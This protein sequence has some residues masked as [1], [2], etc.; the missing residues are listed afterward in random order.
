[1]ALRLLVVAVHDVVAAD[2]D[3][4]DGLHV[5]RHVVHLQVDD[6]DLAARQRPAGHGLAAEA[7]VVVG[8]RDGALVAGAGGN[9]AALGEAVA[10]HDAS[11]GERASRRAISSG[12]DAAPPSM[13]LLQAGDIVLAQA[14]GS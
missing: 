6:A 3:L 11:A 1:M 5:A 2:D 9:G 8:V 7:V 12:E 14:R 4:A 10:G 13:N